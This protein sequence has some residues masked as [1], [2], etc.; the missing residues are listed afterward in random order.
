MLLTKEFIDSV[1]Y[2]EIKKHYGGNC[3]QT[4]FHFH[5]KAWWKPKMSISMDW[6]YIRETEN[7]QLNRETSSIAEFTESLKTAFGY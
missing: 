7:G 3:I 1:K 4:H 6:A 2:Y 5:F